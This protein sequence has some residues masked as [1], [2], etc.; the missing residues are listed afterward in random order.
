MAT[1]NAT[2]ELIPEQLRKLVTDAQDV[3]GKS[4]DKNKRPRLDEENPA[5]VDQGGPHT[6]EWMFVL[7]PRDGDLLHLQ[8]MR[9]QHSLPQSVDPLDLCFAIDPMFVDPMKLLPS[10]FF[11]PTKDDEESEPS[12][13]GVEPSCDANTPAKIVADL[14]AGLVDRRAIDSSMSRVAQLGEQEWVSLLSEVSSPL[15]SLSALQFSTLLQ[16]LEEEYDGSSDHLGSAALASA[17][18]RPEVDALPR[19]LRIAPRGQTTQL[20]STTTRAPLSHSQT[21][22]LARALLCR[23]QLGACSA[24]E[25][26]RS[27]GRLGLRERAGHAGAELETCLGDSFFSSTP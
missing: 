2:L 19:A 17:L 12:Q 16:R 20:A 5:S 25:F 9:P 3:S 8:W 24:G 23:S 26:R 10:R 14:V 21:L 4:S 1:E 18:L 6:N 22:Q 13:R 11:V 7:G 27:L 15:A